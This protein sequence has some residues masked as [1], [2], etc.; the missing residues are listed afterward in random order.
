MTAFLHAIRHANR[1]GLAP[2]HLP[3]R[4]FSLQPLG[5]VMWASIWKVSRTVLADSSR[6]RDGET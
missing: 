4:H 2:E 1:I 6:R 3:G 5:L